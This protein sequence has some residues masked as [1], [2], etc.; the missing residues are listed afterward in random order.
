MAPTTTYPSGSAALGVVRAL[1]PRPSGFCRV[2]RWIVAGALSLACS[3]PPGAGRSLGDDLGTFAIE[4]TRETSDCGPGA[5]GSPAELAYDIELAR[6]DTELFWDGRGGGRVGTDLDFEVSSSSRFE[7][8]AGRGA[9]AGCTIVRDDRIM[10]A[11]EPDALGAIVALRAEM[12]F[13]FALLAGA[14]CT[15]AEQDRAELP[16]L[17]CRMSYALS[18][19]RTRAPEPLPA[20]LGAP[21]PGGQTSTVAGGRRTMG[22]YGDSRRLPHRDYRGL[23]LQKISLVSL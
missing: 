22:Q 16:R 5:L 14:T 2:A 13:R 3:G 17:P 20:A 9:D 7:L 8:R 23:P 15:A 18:G 6:A 19:R 12:I 11:L 21:E 4:A 10:G 1:A